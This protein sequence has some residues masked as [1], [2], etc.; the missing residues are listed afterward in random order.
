MSDRQD[1]EEEGD[2][3]GVREPVGR[4]ERAH[5]ANKNIVLTVVESTII[6]GNRSFHFIVSTSAS[7]LDHHHDVGY[8]HRQRCSGVRKRHNED[9][10]LI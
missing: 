1:E 3:A 9:L 2:Q 5:V 4:C 10:A 7:A 8:I 6:S